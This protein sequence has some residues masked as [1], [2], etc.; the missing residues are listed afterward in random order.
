MWRSARA[1]EVPFGALVASDPSEGV[2]VLRAAD[3]KGLTS[4]DCA[5]SS[6][7]PFPFDAPRRTELYELR[8][9]GHGFE[10]ASAHAPGTTENLV[11][12]SGRVTI[13]VGREVFQL[14]R[15]DA[16]LFPA[17]QEHTYENPDLDD[18][19]LYAVITYASSTGS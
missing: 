19:V 12:A 17:D 1:L 6:R 5:F 15:G 11:V 14:E 13:G 9:K 4:H 18:A 16:V 3:A 7:A 2:Q 8:L 10:R